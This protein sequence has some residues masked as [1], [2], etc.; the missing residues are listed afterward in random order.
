MEQFIYAINSVFDFLQHEIT[1][2][3]YVYTLED[4]F[5]ASILLSALG[6]FVGSILK[7]RGE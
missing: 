1:I 5:Y 7:G 3:G 4:V 2:G 6:V